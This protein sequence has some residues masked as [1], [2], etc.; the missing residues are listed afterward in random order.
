MAPKQ[1]FSSASVETDTLIQDE[2]EIIKAVLKHQ[3]RDV[4]LFVRLV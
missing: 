1:T 4:L 2:S 3:H